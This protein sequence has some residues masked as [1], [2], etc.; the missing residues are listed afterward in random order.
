MITNFVQKHNPFRKQYAIQ[1]KQ[2]N[3]L[4]KGF[5]NAWKTNHE[6]LHDNIIARALNGNLV[7]AYLAGTVTRTLGIDIDDHQGKGEAYLLNLYN[8]VVQRVGINPSVLVKSPHGLHAFWYFTNL[9][10]TDHLVE[11]AKNKLQGIPIEVKPSTTEALRIPRTGMIL[12]PDT[13]HR[14]ATPADEYIGAATQY[15]Y[16]ELFN[17]D[18]HNYTTARQKRDKIV[19]LRNAEKLSMIEAEIVPY[20]FLNGIS[21]E[22]FLRLEFAYRSAGLSLEGALDRFKLILDRSFAYNR[23]KSNAISVK[24]IYRRLVCT[25]KKNS[26]P[27]RSKPV[28]PSLFDNPLID[29]L[30]EASPFAKQRELPLRRFLTELLSWCDWHDSI[31]T[32]KAQL[33]V[34][35]WLY[36]Y[37][38]KN[39]KEG[40][41][42]LPYNQ[43]KQ[44]NGHYTEIL[45]WLKDINI[46]KESEYTYSKNRGICKYYWINRLKLKTKEPTIEGSMN[47]GCPRPC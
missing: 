45:D 10:P 46:I 31:T 15:H 34:F 43:L 2:F 38:R 5:D 24:D 19:S 29:D 8:Q 42:P 22:Q 25:Y 6:Y 16:A 37:Y 27:K 44:W 4:L 3:P 28:Q 18:I 41:Y 36:P 14:I 13:Y 1:Y 23:Y 11:T 47:Q 26:T 17:G 21:N 33:A 39:R 12:D 30:I 7:V 9:L 20:G 32:D 40:L 35:D